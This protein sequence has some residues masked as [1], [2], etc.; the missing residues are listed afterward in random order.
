MTSP[1]LH[2]PRYRVLHTTEGRV[3]AIAPLEAHRLEDG[4]QLGSD[5][6][7]D[8]GQLVTEVQ[9]TREQRERPLAELLHEHDVAIDFAA[10]RL[11]F[12]PRPKAD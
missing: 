3:L 12:T 8:E 10:R 11:V 4:T 1:E 9:L 7:P 5:F 2:P 6:I